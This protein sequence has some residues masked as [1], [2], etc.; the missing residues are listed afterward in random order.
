MLQLIS[1]RLIGVCP[2]FGQ[3]PKQAAIKV[4]QMM[5]LFNIPLDLGVAY[6]QRDPVERSSGS[7][8]CFLGSS[9]QQ[10]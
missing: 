5:I 2:K 9:C 6:F 1:A 3:T 7:D 10:Q 4:G 8:C